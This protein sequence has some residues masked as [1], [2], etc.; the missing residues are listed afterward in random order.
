MH[1]EQDNTSALGFTL[2]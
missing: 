1:R 2:P